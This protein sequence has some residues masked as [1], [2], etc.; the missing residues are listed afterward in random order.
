M[1]QRAENDIQLL[2]SCRAGDANA[3]EE[4]LTT[5]ERL[6]FSIPLNYGLSHD[7]AADVAQQTFIALIESIDTLSADSRLGAW[8]ATVARRQTWRVL[9]RQRREQP[10]SDL[11]I[12]K[13]LQLRPTHPDSL[14]RWELIEWLHRGIARLGERCRE[15]L[16]A[17][18][19]APHEPP[20]TEV[21]TRLGLAVGSI[22]PTRAR[23]LEQLRQILAHES[24]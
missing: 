8:L 4:V 15:L 10:D 12:D 22:G 13:A 19:F 6:V 3:W 20:Y 9:E 17:L 11:L 18:Y 24:D 16:L 14:E 21:A 5:Y 1:E 2:R 23:C 7:E